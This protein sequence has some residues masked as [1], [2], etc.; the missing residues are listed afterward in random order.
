LLGNTGRG[1]TIMSLGFLINGIELFDEPAV[2]MAFEEKKEEL[3]M[4]VRSLGHN[5]DKYIANNKL[6]I[7]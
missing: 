1:K 3:M 4:N 2:F 7:E 5:L 6:Y